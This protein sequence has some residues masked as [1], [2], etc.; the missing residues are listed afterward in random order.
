MPH[1]YVARKLVAFWG[2]LGRHNT[3]TTLAV[4]AVVAVPGYLKLQAQADENT[5]QGECNTQ[6]W[7]LVAALITADNGP[8][9]VTNVV[10]SQQADQGDY[11]KLRRT[12]RIRA[13]LSDNFSRALT[14]A[15]AECGRPLPLPI[16]IPKALQTP[17]ATPDGE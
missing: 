14:N 15:A 12:V 13:E 17:P 4:V 2:Y 16:D 7:S 10:L 6:A 1:R 5:R 9:D 8:W 11:S 3:I